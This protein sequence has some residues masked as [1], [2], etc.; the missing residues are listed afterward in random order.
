MIQM[1]MM[2]I[3]LSLFLHVIRLFSRGAIVA[4]NAGSSERLDFRFVDALV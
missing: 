2:S 4:Q 1:I 3:A